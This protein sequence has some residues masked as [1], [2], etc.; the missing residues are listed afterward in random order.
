MAELTEKRIRE[1]VREETQKAIHNELN[2]ILETVIS[3]LLQVYA[4]NDKH[5]KG[6]PLQIYNK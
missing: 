4:Q 3:N 5:I 2:L 6:Q 1:I